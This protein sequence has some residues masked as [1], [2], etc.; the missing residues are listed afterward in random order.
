MYFAPQ[1]F[2]DLI[3]LAM[4]AS[5]TIEMDPF[6]LLEKLFKS[7]N[8]FTKNQLKLTLRNIENKKITKD[9][10]ESLIQKKKSLEDVIN[11]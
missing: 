4:D 9:E 8:S 7:S 5:D 1:S 2:V 11:C 6:K 3:F 10:F